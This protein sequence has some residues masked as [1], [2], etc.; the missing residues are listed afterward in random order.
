MYLS[1]YLGTLVITLGTASDL[2]ILLMTVDRFHL[3]SNVEK[4]DGGARKV[5]IIR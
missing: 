4:L 2:F 1:S 3:L 5:W